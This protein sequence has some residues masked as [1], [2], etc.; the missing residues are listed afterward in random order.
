MTR[1][2]ISL[3]VT[4][5]LLALLGCQQRPLTPQEIQDQHRFMTGC[6]AEDAARDPTDFE[7]YCDRF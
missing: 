6:R 5:G 1:A 2:G 3:L 4:L 7:A